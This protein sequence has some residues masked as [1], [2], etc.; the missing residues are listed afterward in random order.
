MGAVELGD[1]RRNERAIA[2]G[3]ALAANPGGSLPEQLQGWN[4][5]RAAYRLL[6]E[7]DVSHERL[8]APHR[9]QTHVRAEQ[10]E[11]E[12]VLFIQDTSELDYSSERPRP[13]LGM[14]GKGTSQGLLMHSC[15]AVN[16]R[17]GNPEILGLAAQQVWS[18]SA[19][20]QHQGSGSKRQAPRSEGDKWA[21]SIEAIGSVPVQTAQ[22]WVSVG[23]RESDVF[24]YLRR[25]RQRQWHSLVRVSQN[26]VVTTA[27]QTRS[28]L[29]TYARSLAVQSQKPLRLRGREGE[30]Q[31]TVM[32][33]L[34]WAPVTVHPPQGGPERHRAPISM[35]CIRCWEATADGLEWILLTTVDPALYSPAVQV[36]WYACRWLIEEYHKCLKTGCRVE[37]RQLETAAGLMRLLGFL[38]IVAVR[39]LQLR[40]LSR[41]APD[42]PAQQVVPQVLLQVLVKR[43]GL[44]STQMSLAQFW[45]AVARLGGF[46]GRK[47]DGQPGWQTLW[48]GWLRLQDLA[49]G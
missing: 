6:N 44:F 7:A 37:Q 22:V 23:D 3:T 25:C 40:T 31:R 13:G 10:A 12:V 26:R 45:Q 1:S 39:L 33:N 4:D 30:P 36:E 41:L 16:P 18:R 48:R 34:A 24:S 2:I 21:E 14:I 32:L 28:H 49:W 8:S 47:S 46:I 35:W 15:L 11:S 19:T 38:A 5:L 17:A 29:K 9:A 43:L 27:Q 20:P 42:T